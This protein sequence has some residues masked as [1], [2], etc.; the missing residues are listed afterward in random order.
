MLRSCRRAEVLGGGVRRL[1]VHKDKHCKG[2]SEAGRT[3]EPV[4][5]GAG[6]SKEGRVWREN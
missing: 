2:N 1:D 4:V 3:F 5:T 6:V